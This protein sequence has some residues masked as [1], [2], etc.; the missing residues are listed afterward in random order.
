MQKQLQF[1]MQLLIDWPP[2]ASIEPDSSS[3]IVVA[4]LVELPVVGFSFDWAVVD[5][6]GKLDNSFES[7][8]GGMFRWTYPEFT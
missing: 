1:S 6:G 5:D 2:S 7:V 3:Y 8:D 4:V